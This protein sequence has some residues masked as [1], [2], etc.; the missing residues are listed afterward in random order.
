MQQS[1]SPNGEPTFAGIFDEGNGR[2]LFHTA[3]GLLHRLT[4]DEAKIAECIESGSNPPETKIAQY[5]QYERLIGK[6]FQDPI[7]CF[8]PIRQYSIGQESSIP[9]IAAASKQT[10]YFYREGNVEIV[11]R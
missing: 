1:E 2:Y 8:S 10:M 6:Q 9:L 3:K 11:P 7:V 4:L 5:A